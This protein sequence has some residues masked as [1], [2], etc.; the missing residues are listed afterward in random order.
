MLRVKVSP[1]QAILVFPKFATFGCG[2]AV[3]GGFQPAAHLPAAGSSGAL[4]RT[5]PRRRIPLPF[6][7]SGLQRGPEPFPLSRLER[8]AAQ[9]A[10]AL[11][12]QTAKLVHQAGAHVY[13]PRRDGVDFSLQ[14]LEIAAQARELFQPPG[15]F[16]AR[17]LPRVIVR[18]ADLHQVVQ[19]QPAVASVFIQGE[20]PLPHG[21]RAGKR[22]AH[23]QVSALHALGQVDLTL[24]AEQPYRAHFLQI[25][26]HRIVDGGML[27]RRLFVLSVIFV[28]GKFAVR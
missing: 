16:R 2:F 6:P 21:R 10:R 1:T 14:I 5:G 7:Q 25:H 20:H 27:R 11:H 28:P 18:S 15:N 4:V 26:A 17:A 13:V 8:N 24:P 23:A 3:A 12:L 9:F 19:A 22:L